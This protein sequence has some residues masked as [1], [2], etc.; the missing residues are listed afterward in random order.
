MAVEKKILKNFFSFDFY[1]CFV[2]DSRPHIIYYC[3][4]LDF[5]I[6]TTVAANVKNCKSIHLFNSKLLAR[7]KFQYNLYIWKL[8]PFCL[9]M[10]LSYTKMVFLQKK[11]LSLDFIQ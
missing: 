7:E 4:S 3:S 8:K 9:I 2:Y 10:T 6:H 5:F 1:L 11:F